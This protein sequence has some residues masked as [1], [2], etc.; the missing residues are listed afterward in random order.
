MSAYY[1]SQVNC[2]NAYF[3]RGMIGTSKQIESMIAQAAEDAGLNTA[4][5]KVSVMI[6]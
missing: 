3:D 6:N 4:Q 1:G 2:L 5:V